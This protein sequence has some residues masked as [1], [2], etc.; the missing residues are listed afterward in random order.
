MSG[1]GDRSRRGASFER[2]SRPWR[3]KGGRTRGPEE[4]WLPRLPPGA[5]V[6]QLLA[7]GERGPGAGGRRPGP[8]RQGGKRGAPP[9]AFAGWARRLP[10]TTAAEVLEG[11]APAPRAR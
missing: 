7:D 8:T 11:H 9:L 5:A 1:P 4:R 6:L 10:A 3:R 2:I